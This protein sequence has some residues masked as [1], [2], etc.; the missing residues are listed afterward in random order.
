MFEDIKDDVKI[1]ANKTDN[2]SKKDE[3]VI[4]R[5]ENKKDPSESET[6][7]R[8]PKA[9]YKGDGRLEFL[10]DFINLPSVFKKFKDE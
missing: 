4:L 6:A 8:Q 2:L 3:P 1:D 10:I 7:K 5:Q 9:L